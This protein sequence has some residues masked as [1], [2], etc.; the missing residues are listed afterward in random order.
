MYR[1]ES[2]AGAARSRSR[3]SAGKTQ[4]AHYVLPWYDGMPKLG[5]QSMVPP[6]CSTQG[7]PLKVSC[8]DTGFGNRIINLMA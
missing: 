6:T 8:A 1:K 5:S 4:P 7:R 3:A 2:V